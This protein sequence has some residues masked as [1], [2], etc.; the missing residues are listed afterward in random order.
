[1][2]GRAIRALIAAAGIVLAALLLAGSAS[3]AGSKPRVLA[4]QFGPDLEVNPV[5]QDYLTHQLSQAASKHYDAA[6]I[7]LDTPGG[8]SS[9]MKKI[10]TAELNAKLPVI[11]YVSPDGARAASAGVWIA[12]AADVL[13][14][15]PTTN[16][17]SSTPI[18]SSGANLGSD[19]RRKVINDA[20]ASLTAL[21]AAHHRNTTWP[22]VAVRKASNLTAEQ[23]LKMNV[24]DVVAPSLPALLV[25]LD[26]YRTKDAERPYTLHLAGAQID[27]VKPG[28]FTR[29]LNAT[30]DPTILSLLFLA[31]IVGLGF[32][33]FHPGIVLPG[34][35]GA[36][37]LLTALFGFSVLP[38][39]WSAIALIVLGVALLVIDAHVVTHG[40]LTISGLIALGFGMVMLFHNAPAPYHTSVPIVLAFT[41]VLGLFWVFALTKAVQVRRRPPSVGPARVVGAEAVVRAPDQV[42]V[43]GELWHAHRADGG[44]LVLGSHVRVAGMEGLELIVTGEE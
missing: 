32:E 26:G 13:A 9:S 44:E 29:L 36:V 20:A 2:N 37:A 42:F 31:G 3:A 25:K 1:V 43:E 14:M 6:V 34:A 38:I 10:Y 4:I 12:Q 35:L 30:I 11:V 7:L 33:V 17:G 22:G 21:A 24:I 41:L 23:A 27:T 5:T 8:L 28:F 39:S 18:D 16:I 19:L 40:A 15:A